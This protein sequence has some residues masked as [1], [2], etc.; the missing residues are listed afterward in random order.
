MLNDAGA[1]KGGAEGENVRRTL[2]T[3]LK[4]LGLELLSQRI[5]TAAEARSK[6]A[7]MRAD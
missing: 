2:S 3:A 5:Q 6:T 4:E 1:V 7:A